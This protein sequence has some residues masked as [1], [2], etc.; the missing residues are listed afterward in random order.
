MSTETIGVIALVVMLGLMLF[1]VPIAISI[2]LPG[3]VGILY[4]KDWTVLRNAVDSIIWNHSL[5]YTM[6]TIPMFMWMGE[7]LTASGISSELYNSFRLWL[8]RLKGGLAMA[9]IGASAVFAAASGS[10]VA[11]TGTIGMMA[12]REMLK[13]KYSKPLASGSIVA[14]GTLGILIPPS[15]FLIIYGMLTEQSIGKLLLAGI[16]PGIILSL[17]FVITIF[18]S[19]LIKPDLAPPA[20]KASWKE[21]FVSIK[22]TIWILILFVIVIGGMFFGF[23]GPTE[24]A[25][26]GALAATLLALAKGKL[27]WKVFWETLRR[28]TLSSG[29][30]FAIIL[31]AFLF[32]YFLTISKVPTMLSSLLT[33]A[34]YPPLVTFIMIFIMYVILGAVMDSMAAL[35]VT[36]PIVMP[37]IESLGH[38]LIWF[39]IVMC[40]L[41]EVALISPPHGMNI[42]VLNG[43]VPEYGLG[44]IFIGALLFVIPI[45]FMVALLYIFPDIVLFLPDRMMG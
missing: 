39:G 15:G 30:L 35:V 32:N 16:I 31:A 40:L 19:V 22:S 21:R 44:N 23:F 2:A 36:I 26:I 34:G 9:T 13:F 10:S 17:L 7:M 45:F 25:G 12:S 38:D 42:M 14:G 43:V 27:T 29:F 8:G 6:S 3:V 28:T 5:S 24:A 20:E 4:L 1:R 41:V 18:V 11:N 33:D 37:I